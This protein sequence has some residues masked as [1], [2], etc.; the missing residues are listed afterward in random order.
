MTECDKWDIS[1][2]FEWYSTKHGGKAAPFGSGHLL[3]DPYYWNVSS[4]K[5]I[6]AFA[7]MTSAT[8]TSP[9]SLAQIQKYLPNTYKAYFEISRSII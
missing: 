6:E 3:N 5:S 7:E 1:D 8:I 4:N 2:M 9:E